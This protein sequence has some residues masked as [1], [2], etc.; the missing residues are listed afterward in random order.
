MEQAI[1]ETATITID[2]EAWKQAKSQ[3]ALEDRTLAELVE[4]AIRG[5]LK[6]NGKK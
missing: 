2:R 1:K 4:D 3:A 5:Y 6:H